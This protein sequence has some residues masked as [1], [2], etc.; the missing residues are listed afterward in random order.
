MSRSSLVPWLLVVSLGCAACSGGGTSASTTTA[1]PTTTTA[2]LPAVS[3]LVAYLPS[4][5]EFVSMQAA[6][7]G[8]I[9]PMYVDATQASEDRVV[10]PGAEEVLDRPD[11]RGGAVRSFR[12]RYP[13]ERKFITISLG[14]FVPEN[15]SALQLF[16]GILKQR[17][18]NDLFLIEP[19]RF[20]PGTVS[21]KPEQTYAHQIPRGTYTT[22]A[23]CGSLILLV[24]AS[25][26]GGNMLYGT[27]FVTDAF[28]AWLAVRYPTL[29]C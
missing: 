22:W 26:K 13:D 29:A 4:E 1:L 20:P 27:E 11:V 18:G 5:V 15:E 3:E 7:F 19:D 16:F 9:D 14:V 17:Y 24:K 25:W 12:T 6:L 2:E 21:G 8:G 23:Q 28:A 10:G